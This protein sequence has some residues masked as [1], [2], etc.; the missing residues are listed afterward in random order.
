MEQYTELSREP[1]LDGR[2]LASTYVF[3]PLHDR[4]IPNFRVTEFTEVFWGRPQKMEE[5]KGLRR[6][7]HFIDIQTDPIIHDSFV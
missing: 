6:R 5:T 2:D 1:E 4:V 3:A 7:V